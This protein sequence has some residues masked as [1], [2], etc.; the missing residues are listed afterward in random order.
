MALIQIDNKS[1]SRLG[2]ADLAV[3]VVLGSVLAVLLSGHRP[4]E[5]DRPF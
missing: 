3:V 2:L 5:L 4:A 1:I